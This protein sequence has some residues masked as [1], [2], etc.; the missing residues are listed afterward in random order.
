MISALQRFGEALLSATFCRCWPLR[1][2]DGILPWGELAATDQAVTGH[3]L[4]V[5][6]GKT[7]A[8]V[9]LQMV[10]GS[11]PCLPA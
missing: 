2:S 7:T 10:W 5:A 1:T 11:Q 4:K 6:V 8:A 3:K 9:L